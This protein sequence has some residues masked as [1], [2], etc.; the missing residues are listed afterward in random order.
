M[1]EVL[2]QGEPLRIVNLKLPDAVD[3]HQAGSLA[4]RELQRAPLVKR[5]GSRWIM[6]GDWRVT[7][8]DTPPHPQVDFRFQRFSIAALYQGKFG[9]H[10]YPSLGASTKDSGRW[11]LDHRDDPLQER[12]TIDHALSSHGVFTGLTLP[13]MSLPWIGDVEQRAPLWVRWSLRDESL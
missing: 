5:L 11:R 2:D 9:A 3:K 1:M 12:A 10:M 6:M 7:P 8:P 4:L 13:M